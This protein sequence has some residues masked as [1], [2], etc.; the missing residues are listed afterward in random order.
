MDKL[1]FRT[2]VDEKTKKIVLNKIHN[3]TGVML[4]EEYANQSKIVGVFLHNKLVAGYMLVT[5]PSF[6]SLLFVPD[7]TKLQNDT[8]TKNKSDF[9]EVNGLWI[10]PALKTPWY[11]M[12][13]WFHLIWDIFSCRKK[14]VLLMRNLNNKSMERFMAMSN[15]ISIYEGEPFVMAGQETHERIQ[16]S[17][18]SRWSLIVN[19]Y[20][21]VAELIRRNNKATNFARQNGVVKSLKE[22]YSN[23]GG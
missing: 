6:R 3:Y 21:Y 7:K 1:D 23:L 2:I 8:L 22:S 11:Q 19:S 17:Y 16:V 20:K 14:Y 13:V 9:M 5:K 12:R 15:P 4:P 10:S 18:T